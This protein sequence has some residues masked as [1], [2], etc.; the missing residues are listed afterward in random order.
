MSQIYAMVLA[1]TVLSGA[2]LL[3]YVLYLASEFREPENKRRLREF[4]NSNRN[5]IFGDSTGQPE[6]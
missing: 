5:H 3:A 2:G 4:H 1:T 6:A